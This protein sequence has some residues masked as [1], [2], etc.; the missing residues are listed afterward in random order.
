MKTEFLNLE[1]I[2][3]MKRSSFGIIED[4]NLVGVWGT[5][6]HYLAPLMERIPSTKNMVLET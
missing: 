1:E 3:V 5:N 2:K 6:H 4:M